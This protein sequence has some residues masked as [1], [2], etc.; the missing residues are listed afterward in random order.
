MSTILEPRH[1]HPLR[2]R[3]AIDVARET[4]GRHFREGRAP[5]DA[6]RAFGL[7]PVDTTDWAA[8]VNTVAE[9]LCAGPA[10]LQRVA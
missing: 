5:G 6:V 1:V 10:P 2:W 4:C 9:V 7:A 8:A 3:Q